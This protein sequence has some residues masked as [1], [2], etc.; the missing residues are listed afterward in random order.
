MIILADGDFPT[1]GPA[2]LMLEKAGLRICCDGSAQS[3][4]EAGWEPDAIVGDMDSL[5]GELQ[6]R[7]HDRIVRSEDQ[8][9]NDLT[10][11]VRH[12]V[13]RGY[14]KLILLGATGK[15][16]DHSL[17]NISLMTEYAAMAEVRMISDYGEFFLVRSGEEISSRRGEQISIF[18]LDNTV[19]VHGDGLRY[20]LNGL[21]LSHW[22]T[23][24]LNEAAGE[25][26]CLHFSGNYLIIYRSFG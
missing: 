21:R 1:R 26:F 24:S 6:E 15:R 20:P 11:A 8:D 5:P 2:L 13:S 3:L 22:Y 10:K 14:R 7:F 19:E 16:E 9:C 4:L 17:G 25:S 12:C 23:A 18:S